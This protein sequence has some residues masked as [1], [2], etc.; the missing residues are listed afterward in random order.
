M[1]NPRMIALIEQLIREDG[2]TSQ[3]PALGGV[4]FRAYTQFCENQKKVSL[5]GNAK[6][7]ME[8]IARQIAKLTQQK[9]TLEQDISNETLRLSKLQEEAQKET[10]SLESDLADAT[11]VLSALQEECQA[12]QAQLDDWSNKPKTIEQLQYRLKTLKEERDNLQ[13]QIDLFGKN[14]SDTR[15]AIEKMRPLVTQLEKLE[16]QLDKLM[17]SLWGGLKKDTFDMIF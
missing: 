11:G 16:S 2:L 14:A 1:D 9:Q 15:N 8:D 5:L 4:L 17:K 7:G 3:S 13:S 10:A 12:L 6:Q